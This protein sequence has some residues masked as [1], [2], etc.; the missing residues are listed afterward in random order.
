M[1]DPISLEDFARRTTVRPEG[2]GW[3][4]ADRIVSLRQIT[5]VTD[6][7]LMNDEYLTRL[8]RSVTLTG[9]PDRRPYE[10]CKVKRLRADPEMLAVGQTFVEERKL[11][12]LQSDFSAVFEGSGAS[13]GFA[14][15]GAMI[16]LGETADGEHALAHYLPPIIEWHGDRHGLLDGMHRCYSAMRVGTT[17]EIIKVCFPTLP[18]PCAFGHWRDVRL[19]SAKPPKEDRFMDLRPDL[20]RD[21]KYVGIDG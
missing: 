9:D 7:R 14:K 4:G 10:G 18:F 16:V 21:L 2:S 13:R 5:R 20:F 8:L 15:K 17:V 6:I 12:D 11:L 1:F 19:V 3:R